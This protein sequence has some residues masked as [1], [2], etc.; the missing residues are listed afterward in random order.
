M[1][2]PERKPYSVQRFRGKFALVWN[3]DGKRRRRQLYSEDKPSAEAEARRIWA[4]GDDTPWTMG[5]VMAGYIAS[6]E[7]DNRPSAPRRR[8]A[9]KA[10][11][12]FWERTEPLLVDEKMCRDYVAQRDAAASTQRY[13][14]L[15]ISTALSWARANTPVTAKPKMWLPKGAEAGIKHLSHAQFER[16]LEQVKAP[17]AK[18][19][20]LLGLYTM[21]RPAAVLDLVWDQVDFETGLIDLNPPGRRQTRKARPT[22]PMND[23]LREALLIAFEARQ[24][25]WVIE[26]G[27]KKIANMKKAFQAASQRSG[28]KATPYSLRHTGAVWAAS[29]GAPMAK[30][31]QFMGHDD[32]STTQRHYAKFQPE[33]LMDVANA[34]QRMRK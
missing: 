27:G 31:A 25:K 16:F 12:L 18:L 30:L 4:A 26:R 22:V 6:L 19:Y 20:M 32:D 17:H 24:T 2:E 1:S 28:I 3:A 34:V 5:K 29:N 8:D 33:H 23:D 13:E 11:R 14:L 7:L 15:Q 9:W 10:M 21:A